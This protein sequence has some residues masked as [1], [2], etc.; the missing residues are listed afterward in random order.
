VAEPATSG[1]APALSPVRR[2]AAS[3]L[4]GLAVAALVGFLWQNRRYI[5]LHYAPHPWEFALLAALVVAVLALRSVAHQALFGRLGI[6]ASAPDWFRLVTVSSFTNYLPLS[7][8]LV[9]K[10][11]FLKRVHALP[12][13]AFA[14]G[15]VALLLMILATNGALGLATLALAF[16][17]QLTG[18][19][20]AGFA[21]MTAAG[22]LLLLPGLKLPGPLRR[23]IPWDDDLL[24]ELRRAWLPVCL[25]QVGVLLAT[26][27]SLRVCFAMGTADVPL[28]ACTIF[29]AAAMLTRLVAVTPGAIGI[30]EFLV[31][32]LAVLTGF[33][34][35]D[36]VI[37]AT[38]ARTVEVA[39][40]FTLGSLFTRRVSGQALAG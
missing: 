26:A 32:G 15:Q 8:G 39:V 12:Y 20:G 30:R 17:E 16:P 27:V 40:V 21:A 36:A 24:P 25:L 38:T 4:A 34:L 3:G 33:E 18:I 7:A 29:S 1:P 37:A 19:L 14:V 5:A 13:G 11:F 6:R 28:S 35:R 23:R 10:A 22:G 2:A 9:A 31:G